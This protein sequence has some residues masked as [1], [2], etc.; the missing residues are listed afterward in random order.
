MTARLVLVRHGQASFGSPDYDLLSEIGRRQSQ[1]AGLALAARLPRFDRVVSGSMRRHQETA[2]GCLSAMGH[3]ATWEKEDGWNEFDHEE[4]IRVHEPRFANDTV[5]HREMALV[6]DA[7]VAFLTL[8]RAAFARWASGRHD[9]DYRETYTAFRTR[10]ATAVSRAIAS[11]GRSGSV[12]VFTSG[13]PIAAAVGD[14]LGLNPE[15]MLSLAFR[16][17]NAGITELSARGDG[18]AVETLNDHAHL[19]GEAGLLT[20]R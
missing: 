4:L 14:R 8:F 2:A 18:I 6:P 1:L 5:L 10:V 16:L 19:E 3:P 13:G 12:L 11:A 17:A 20:H 7:E 15:R 9:G